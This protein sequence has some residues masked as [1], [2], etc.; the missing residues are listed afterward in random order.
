MPEIEQGVLHIEVADDWSVKDFSELLITLDYVYTHLGT[1][2]KISDDFDQRIRAFVGD[3]RYFHKYHPM[4]FGPSRILWQTDREQLFTPLINAA[5]RAN[6]ALVLR[7]IEMHSPGW[8]DV[9]GAVGV[10]KLIRDLYIAYRKDQTERLR[11]E[12]NER[13]EEKKATA[14]VLKALAQREDILS[15]VDVGQLMDHFIE[16]TREQPERKIK[17]LS[18]DLRIAKLEVKT[19]TD[20]GKNIEQNRD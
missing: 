18:L 15:H 10:L 4:E 8:I 5:T 12:S 9:A 16:D 11:I 2:H 3:F 1:F 7:A 13:I 19:L 6:G 14:E 20:S 17:M